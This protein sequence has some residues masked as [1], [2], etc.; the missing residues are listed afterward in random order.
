[1]VS[2]VINTVNENPEILKRAVD[3]YLKQGAQVIIST[4]E[5]DPSLSLKGVDFA[6][7]KKSDHPGKS[8]KGSFMQLNNALP[9]IRGEWFCFA[10]GNDYS[11]AWKLQSEVSACISNNKKVCYSAFLNVYG[12][13]YKVKRF[14]EYDY[15][16][17]LKG[18]FVSDCALVHVS[19]LNKYGPF[20]IEL[21]NYAFWD[22]WLR[23]YEGEGNVF[24]YLNSPTWFYVQNPNDMHNIRKRSPKQMKEAERD[25]DFMLS[26]HVN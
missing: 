5:N 11:S 7:M 4:I 17:H 3:S 25:R 19:L 2:V 13:K 15:Q 1:M 6:T 26:F 9:L 16:K 24:H 21:N 10:S 18:N 20:R 14:H 22:F 12:K 8:P 23:I